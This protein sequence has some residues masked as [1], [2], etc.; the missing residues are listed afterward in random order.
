MQGFWTIQFRGVQG[1]GS[2]VV[3]LID[4]D[5]FGGDGGYIYTGSYKTNGP[6]LDAQVHVKAVRPWLRKCYGTDGIR[7]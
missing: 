5:I 7:S 3:T 1:F 4:G 6:T 2:G